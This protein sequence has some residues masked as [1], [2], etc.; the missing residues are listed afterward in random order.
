VLAHVRGHTSYMTCKHSYVLNSHAL[1]HTLTL[2]TWND[3]AEHHRW[4]HAMEWLC[5]FAARICHSWRKYSEHRM[6]DHICLL[7]L[8][9][10]SRVPSQELSKSCPFCDFQCH[11]SDLT[12]VSNALDALSRVTF[13]NIWSRR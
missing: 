6:S 8:R 12:R 11:S 3:W 1:I 4:A 10:V 2:E 5:E 13:S 9:D 7:S